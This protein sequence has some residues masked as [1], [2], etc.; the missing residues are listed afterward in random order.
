MTV[1]TAGSQL[2]DLRRIRQL[3]QAE[4]ATRSGVS[5]R[6]IRALESGQTLRPHPATLRAL[7]RG[8]GLSEGQT[9]TFVRAFVAPVVADMSEVLGISPLVLQ[10]ELNG[11]HDTAH[12]AHWTSDVCHCHQVVGPDGHFE[13]NRTHRVIRSTI[14]GLT[15]VMCLVAYE[16]D[17]DAV[18]EVLDPFGVEVSQQWLL[19]EHRIA[20]IEFVLPR[21]LAVGDTHAYGYTLD[22]SPPSEVRRATEPDCEVIEGSRGPVGTYVLEV[23][24]TGTP[25]AQ[26]VPFTQKGADGDERLHADPVRPDE[27]GTVRLQQQNTPPGRAFGFTWSW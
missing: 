16:Y 23:Q 6:A 19:A 27:A 18:P 11:L 7:A 22:E 13:L 2:R 25:P 24:F 5:Q 26:I 8:L 12:A 14:S 20:V 15:H 4:L 3:T 10:S 1:A 17:V 9:M 21:P